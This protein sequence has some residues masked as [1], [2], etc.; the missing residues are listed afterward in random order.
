MTILGIVMGNKRYRYTTFICKKEDGRDLWVNT[1]N[2]LYPPYFGAITKP[3][4]G[5]FTSHNITIDLNDVC[6]ASFLYSNYLIGRR[7]NYVGFPGE[8][9]TEIT[10]AIQPYNVIA[11]PLGVKSIQNDPAYAVWA[12]GTRMRVYGLCKRGDGK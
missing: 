7:N 2:L 1:I 9:Y 12:N 8:T 10:R 11:K 3:R 6:G 5:I 4:H